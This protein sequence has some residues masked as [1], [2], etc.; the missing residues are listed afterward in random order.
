MEATTF[1]KTN[2]KLYETAEAANK[3]FNEINSTLMDVY[4]KQLNLASSFYNNLFNSFP[5]A[6]KNVWNANMDF[7]K[8]FGADGVSKLFSP[9]NW[10]KTSDY[11][12]DFFKPQTEGLLKK[13]VE[14]NGNWVTELQKQF[15]IAQMNWVELSEKTQEIME[16]EW[17]AIYN[18]MK[19]LVETYNRQADFS[20]E[21]SRKFMEKINEQFDLASKQSEKYWSDILKTAQSTGNTEIENVQSPPL[22]KKQNKVEFVTSHNNKH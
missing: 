10:L 8:P 14:F 17:K 1:G 20:I 7:T 19:S 15:K 21:S 6:N 5:W 4:S 18:T 13:A 11:L 9:F 16:E 22:A 12:S 2:E 3:G